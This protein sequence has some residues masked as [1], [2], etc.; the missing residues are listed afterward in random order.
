MSAS[1]LILESRLRIGSNFFIR[2]FL[3]VSFFI[4]NQSIIKFILQNF[5]TDAVDGMSIRRS[6]SFSA[7][8][9]FNSV[10]ILGKFYKVLLNLCTGIIS[11]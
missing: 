7:D 5:I 8:N 2:I 3:D 6:K 11:N 9:Y 10:I 1:T 4:K